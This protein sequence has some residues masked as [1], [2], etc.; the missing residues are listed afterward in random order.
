[1][2]TT[3]GPAYPT[4][5]PAVPSRWLL[6]KRS[7][8]AGAEPS[9]RASEVAHNPANANMD[10]RIEPSPYLFASRCFTVRVRLDAPNVPLDHR[11]LKPWNEGPTNAPPLDQ[12]AL[13]K[14][15]RSRSVAPIN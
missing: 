12:G 10:A 1:M 8:S 14:T 2:T 9:A 11:A 3:G 13:S 5:I 7:I 6:S 15:A 4:I